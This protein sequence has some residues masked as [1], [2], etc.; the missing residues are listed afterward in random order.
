MNLR[1]KTWEL[2]NGGSNDATTPQ[3]DAPPTPSSGSQGAPITPDTDVY[4]KAQ[5]EE[6]LDPSLEHLEIAIKAAAESALE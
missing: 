2:Y 5:K 4:I 1:F 3:K 6:Y